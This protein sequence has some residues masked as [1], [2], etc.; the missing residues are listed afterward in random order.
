[1]T[2]RDSK[3]GSVGQ[4]PPPLSGDGDAVR[5]YPCY[6]RQLKKRSKNRKKY[7]YGIRHWLL[8]LFPFARQRVYNGRIAGNIVDNCSQLYGRRQGRCSPIPAFRERKGREDA[9]TPQRKYG[10]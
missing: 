5:P 4:S 2:F 1:M 10:K 8:K 7:I 9:G 6:R 3:N